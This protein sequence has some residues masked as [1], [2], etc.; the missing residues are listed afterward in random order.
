MLYN[1]PAV[2]VRKPK[3]IGTIQKPK[4]SKRENRQYAL[5]AALTSL[6]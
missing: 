3:D 2:S 1:D 4:F 5:T 6:I